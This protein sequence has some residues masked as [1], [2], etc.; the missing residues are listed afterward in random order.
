LKPW[1]NKRWCI[2]KITGDYIW[3]MEDVLE[4]YARPYD[5]RHPLICYDERPCQLLGDVLVPL[6]MKPGQ[7][8]RYD[9]EYERNGTCCVL[10]AFEPH[11]GFRYVQ[12]RARRT[13]ADYAQF[14]QDLVR[15]HYPTVDHIRLVQ[16]NLNTHTPGSFYQILPPEAAFQFAQQFELHYTPKKGSWLNMA[17]IE[18]AALATQCLDRRIA[19]QDT[20]E[21]EALTWAH[22][23]N[24]AR[25][26]V[27][28]RFTKYAAR[29]KLKNKYPML[30]N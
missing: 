1:L 6:P 4:Q 28:W 26:T 2:G 7:P 18:F 13:A 5:P 21:K 29:E 30:T 10:L 11:T 25:T 20:L 19:E 27:N 16:D 12:V 3:H 8:V 24:K 14:M 22:N 23:R 17:E 9:Y 15:L